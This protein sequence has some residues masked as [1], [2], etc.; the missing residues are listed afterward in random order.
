[1][2]LY[3]QKRILLIRNSQCGIQ[4]EIL[5]SWRTKNRNTGLLYKEI[6]RSTGLYR[7]YN[8]SGAYKEQ[9]QQRVPEAVSLEMPTLFHKGKK[10]S[11][12]Q[13]RKNSALKAYV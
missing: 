8:R 9:T 3:D 13:A 6:A 4:W 2:K 10:Q 12:H 5:D 1:M 11:G 7:A